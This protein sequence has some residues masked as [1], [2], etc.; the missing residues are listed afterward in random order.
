MLIKMEHGWFAYNDNHWKLK[1]INFQLDKGCFL[2]ILGPNGAGKS[3][4][5]KSLNRIINLTR[6]RIWINGQDI[7]KISIESI[8]QQVAYVPQYTQ[9]LFPSSVF[10]MVLM[11]RIPYS[12]HH[13]NWND[14]NAAYN[15]IKETGLESYLAQ[16]V[17]YLSGGERQRVFIARALAGTPSLLLMDEPTSNL[18]IR[19]Q[20]EI[21]QLIR[22]L[23]REKQ[24]SVI[25]I[26]HDLNL[27]SM[28]CDHIFIIKDGI[29]WKNGTPNE[30]LTPENIKE[31]YGVNAFTFNRGGK[32]FIQLID[33]DLFMKK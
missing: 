18:D 15:A 6:G 21:L 24:L 8:A 10:N 12:R 17:R 30:V 22:R 20:L 1:D 2:G 33:P 3:T 29:L 11:G 13:F 26:I 7:R 23:V 25:M 28:F 19:Y 16:D 32:N 9:A 27:A 5:L 4:L 31:I 14:K